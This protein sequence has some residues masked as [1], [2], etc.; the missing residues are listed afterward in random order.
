MCIL[1]DGSEKKIPANA[2]ML[3][4]NGVSLVWRGNDGY[5]YKRSIPFLIE[6]EIGILKRIEKLGIAPRAERYDKYTIKMKDLGVSQ[7]VI[8]KA[9]F[10]KAFRERLNK[11]HNFGIRHGDLTKYAI[12]VVDDLPYFIDFAESRLITDLRPDKRKEGDEYWM[13]KTIDEIT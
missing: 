7:M 11:L 3:S 8:S 9:K 4:D 10:K 12:V 6:N 1:T 13:E 5:I 2:E